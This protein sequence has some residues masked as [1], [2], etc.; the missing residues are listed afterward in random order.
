MDQLDPNHHD[1][2]LYTQDVVGAVDSFRSAEG[3]S[4]P[5]MGSPPGWVDE[6][7]VGKLWGALD[8]AG[9]SKEVRERLK[10][11]TAVRR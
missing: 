5:A 11:F 9:K 1:A 4:T 7:T 2:F 8:R 10:E 3:L 6:E